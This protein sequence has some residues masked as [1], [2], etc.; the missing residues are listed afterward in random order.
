MT[1]FINATLKINCKD[2]ICGCQRNDEHVDCVILDDGGF[3]VMANRDEYIGQV[4]HSH[5]TLIPLILPCSALLNPKST[6]AQ[7]KST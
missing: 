2:E 7:L 3:L 1:N 4:S 6:L 5:P